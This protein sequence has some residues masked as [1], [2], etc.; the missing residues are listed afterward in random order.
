M[1]GMDI[2]TNGQSVLPIWETVTDAWSKVKG[3]KAQIWIVFIIFGI[4]KLFEE[5]TCRHIYLSQFSF[6]R[7]LLAAITII[8]FLFSLFLSWGVLY[9]GIQRGVGKDIHYNMISN[10]FEVNLFLKMVGLYI[11]AAL[12][13][14]PACIIFFIP[15]LLKESGFFIEHMQISTMVCFLSYILSVWLFIYL[16][17][18]LY[19]CKAIVLDQK[20]NPWSAIKY[21]FQVTRSNAMRLFCLLIVNVVIF[22]ISIIPFGIGLIWF[23]PYFLVNYGVVYRKLVLS[24]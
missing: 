5:Y 6:A 1:I 17:M 8:F 10:I 14:I 11:L 24:H 3:A 18:R 4:A 23:L 21:S 9:L 22:L 20:M 12:I 16:A 13:F 2:M 15:F 7:I 19:V